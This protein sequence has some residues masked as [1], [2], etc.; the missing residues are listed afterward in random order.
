MSNHCSCPQDP[1]AYLPTLISEF[2]ALPPLTHPLTQRQSEARQRCENI[3]RRYA[4]H[5][6][7]AQGTTPAQSRDED[8]RP[9]TLNESQVLE[10]SLLELMPYERLETKRWS[11]QMTYRSLVGN[12]NFQSFAK[13]QQDLR[14]THE[15]RVSQRFSDECSDR[16][17][18]IAELQDMVTGK[19]WLYQNEGKRA[20]SIQQQQRELFMFFIGGFVWLAIL[21]VPLLLCCPCPPESTGWLAPIVLFSTV[22]FMGLTGATI[23]TLR[24]FKKVLDVPI[25]AHDPS[26]TL[27]D[28]FHGKNSIRLSV[29][30]GVISAYL[31]Y[32]F[33]LGG[34]M[35][36]F[37]D[38][39]APQFGSTAL[40]CA[41][42]GG[43]LTLLAGLFPTTAADYAKLL[44]WCVV[45]GFAERLVPDVLDK[46]ANSAGRS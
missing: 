4:Y 33:L 2:H 32:L 26:L 6:A 46:L 12:D 40:P 9:L 18:L 22:G 11:L 21:L 16:E 13:Q 44:V 27:T 14:N 45:A 29:L 37:K 28:L 3:A 39:I 25:A 38:T 30:T 35:G 8:I 31:F 23:S 10:M 5:A 15:Q 34:G 17:F 20:Q 41:H 1:T 7:K 42:Q 43:C 24:R 36:F 19:Y